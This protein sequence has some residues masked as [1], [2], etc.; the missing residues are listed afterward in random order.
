LIEDRFQ[1]AVA[2][3]AA[4]DEP[5]V[6]CSITTLARSRISERSVGKTPTT[7]ARRPV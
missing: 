4:A 6:V 5:F 1:R 3:V 7:S 2:E